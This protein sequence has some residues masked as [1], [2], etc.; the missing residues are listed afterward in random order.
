MASACVVCEVGRVIGIDQNF[1]VDR[2]KGLQGEWCFGQC[3][4]C[5]V[6]CMMP[7]PTDTE[8]AN[9]YAA[10]SVNEKLDLSLKTGSHRPF[11]RKLFHRLT[12]DVDPRDFVEIQTGARVLDFGCGHAGYLNDFHSRGIDVSGAEIAKYVVEACQKNGLDVHHV[13]GFSHIPFADCE[14]DVVYLMQVFEHLREPQVFIKELERIMKPGGFLYLAVPNAD[15]FWRR[16]F[17]SNWVSGWFAP[18]H[19]FHYNRSNLAKLASQHGF[20]LVDSSS[21]TPESWF[22]LNIKASLYPLEN[23]LDSTTNWLDSLPIR[24]IAMLLLRILELPI[25][26]RDCLVVVLQ[27]NGSGL[28]SIETD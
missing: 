28:S 13:D 3:E 17:G 4:H 27:K 25:R 7:M 2:R 19:L 14:F 20:E 8:L 6:I 24:Y 16:F 22:R 1:H 10:Y 18:F 9:Y 21:R 26:E 11:L 5:S 12:G 15:S 23:Q